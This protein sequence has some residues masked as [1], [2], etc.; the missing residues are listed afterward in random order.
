MANEDKEC[1]NESKLWLY[2]GSGFPNEG[3]RPFFT[4]HH[5]VLGQSLWEE[6]TFYGFFHF[7]YVCLI[8]GRLQV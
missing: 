3:F 7:S 1:G 6:N 5:P 4:K 8:F 2:M